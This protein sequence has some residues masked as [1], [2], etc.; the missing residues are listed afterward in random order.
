L[1]TLYK[2][3]LGSSLLIYSSCITQFFPETNEDKH[4][5]VVEGLITDQAEINTIKLSS[6]MNFGSSARVRPMTGCDVI[7]SDDMGNSY[8]FPES[9]PGTYISDTAVFRG[10]VGRV[11]TLH[12]NT[13]SSN[14][15]HVYQS[16]PVEMKAVPSIDSLYYKKVII[17]EEDPWTLLQEGAQVYLNTSDPSGSC[18]F[19]RWEF[20]ET[21]EFDNPYLKVNNRGWVTDNSN[22]INV[23]STLELEEDRINGYPLNFI[24]NKSDRLGVKYSTLVSQYSLNEQEFQYW[25]KLH[26]VSE[27]VGGL[28]DI[29]PASIPSNISCFDDP[30]EKA[31]GYFSV[32]AKATKRLFIKEHF[33]GLINLYTDDACIGDTIYN[34]EEIPNLN[35]SVWVLIDHQMPPPSYK[36]ISYNRVCA[37][38]S[39]RG[40]LIRPDFWDDG[41]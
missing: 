3:L 26:S 6:S 13:N 21:W 10:R 15:N 17:A 28:Y 40:T 20:S 23:K 9:N 30:D 2:L 39:A 29:I 25:D 34:N 22:M 35:I 16:S 41:K 27:N 38:A 31:L 8:T 19:F 1:K 33:S 32:S 5:L 14:A 37:D 7:I 24:S 11:Y 18:K 36:V 12:I 4:L